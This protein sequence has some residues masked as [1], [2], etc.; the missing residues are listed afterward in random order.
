M[1]ENLGKDIIFMLTKDEILACAGEVVI[2]PELLVFEY[3][4]K[5]KEGD[6][7]PKSISGIID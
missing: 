3:M 5:E 7:N 6:R 2:T 4:R 1:E